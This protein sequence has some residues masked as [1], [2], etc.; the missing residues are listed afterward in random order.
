MSNKPK[1]QRD[2]RSDNS[3]V[4]AANILCRLLNHDGSLATLLPHYLTASENAERHSEV[5]EMCYGVMRWYFQLDAVLAKLISKPLRRKDADVR[6]LLLIGLY[7]LL[8]M[9]TPSHAAV[10]ETVNAATILKKTWAK[11]LINGVLRNADRQSEELLATLTPAQQS[12]FPPWLFERLERCWPEH[13][14]QLLAASNQRP[15]M[16]LRVNLTKQTREAALQ[17]LRDAEIEGTSGLLSDCAIT[18]NKASDVAKLP[19]F[20]NGRISVQDE[21][22]QLAA[23][24]LD[25]KEGHSVLDACCAPGGKTGHI[26]ESVNNIA[27]DAMDNSGQRLERV[28]ENLERLGL[29]ATLIEA[30]AS[31]AD[32]WKG[33]EYYQRILLDVPCSATGVI[34]RNPD[35]KY[36][37][38]QDDIAKLGRVQLAMLRTC[39]SKLA[40]GGKLLYSTCSILPEEN[41]QIIA[42]FVESQDDATHDHIV[43]D[44]GEECTYGR[45][46]LPSSHDGFYYA[47]LVKNP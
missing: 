28:S 14:D 18:L 7:Q 25:L 31:D 27:V 46:L 24:L 11:A 9:R 39:W 45:Q 21:G 26:L 37:R 44:W 41:Q 2:L 29:Q 36:L 32:H 22:A 33:A 16:T 5:K 23:T 30:D 10:S 40:P 20:Q 47:R 13:I 42:A 17:S 12:A 4:L 34:R 1:Q 15:P 43:A 8:H 38:R 19:G 6:A 3:R 35:I